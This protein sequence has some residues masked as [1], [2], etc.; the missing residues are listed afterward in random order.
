[1]AKDT[2]IFGGAK[3]KVNAYLDKR[4]SEKDAESYQDEM[5]RKQ[6]VKQDEKSSKN[7]LVL[8]AKEHMANK[9]RQIIDSNVPLTKKIAAIN[10][11]YKE[12]TKPRAMNALKDVS[13]QTYI[14][15]YRTDMRKEKTAAI[16]MA[17]AESKEMQRRERLIKQIEVQ[18]RSELV[19]LQRKARMALQNTRIKLRR[20]K[21]G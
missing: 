6:E 10:D 16:R 2:S 15:R 17:V 9:Q 4:K 7:N 8:K 11:Y 20:I 5:E 1:M 13:D 3:A 18:E 19:K 21:N 14:N 12:Q